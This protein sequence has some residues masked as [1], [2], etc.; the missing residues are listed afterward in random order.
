MKQKRAI[1]KYALA[2]LLGL[3]IVGIMIL[4]TGCVSTNW[5]RPFSACEKAA[6]AQ[7]DEFRRQG[8]ESYIKW[9]RYNMRLGTHAVVYTVDERGKFHTYDPAKG[10]YLD[11]DEY[12]LVFM[13]VENGSCYGLNATKGCY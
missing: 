3:L 12:T 1:S 7:R 8:K 6:I 10:R 2:T 9:I 4:L 11:R 5:E 13:M